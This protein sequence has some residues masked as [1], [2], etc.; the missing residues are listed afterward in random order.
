MALVL[1]GRAKV[2]ADSGVPDDGQ[3]FGRVTLAQNVRSAD[4][5][6]EV[7]AAAADAGAVITRRPA[8]RR[9]TAA[10]PAFFPD[11]DGH[12]WEIAHNPGFTLDDDGALVLPEF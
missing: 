2:A 1:W 4:E 12:V 10:T 3:G 8:R 5:V 7:V 11:P 9:S 6:D